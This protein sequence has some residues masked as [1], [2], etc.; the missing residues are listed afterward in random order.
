ME[1]TP[2][3]KRNP[4][5]LSFQS[6]GSYGLIV[7]NCDDIRWSFANQMGILIHRF[8]VYWHA[9]ECGN[10]LKC[11]P[12]AAAFFKERGVCLSSGT[13]LCGRTAALLLFRLNGAMFN[14]IFTQLMVHAEEHY[15]F[16]YF[17]NACISHTLRCCGAC[18][19]PTGR[20]WQLN[21]PSR[22]FKIPHSSPTSSPQE[23]PNQL[24]ALHLKQKEDISQ[25]STV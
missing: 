6:Q 4:R 20:K 25:L 22:L 5:L 11:T 19:G 15:L 16:C 12:P 3:R 10:Y 14:Y 9:A 7:H 2:Y 8:S 13:V 18:S 17:I 1:L 21:Q 23:E 24:F